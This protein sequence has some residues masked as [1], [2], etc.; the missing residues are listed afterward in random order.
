MSPS[1]TPQSPAT[2]PQSGI[3][4]RWRSSTQRRFTDWTN[5]AID[6]GLTCLISTAIYISTLRDKSSASYMSDEELDVIR[7]YRDTI[8]EFMVDPSKT[9][10]GR[11]WCFRCTYRDD[12]VL[13]DVERG[14]MRL[15]G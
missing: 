10:P 2:E 1:L 5:E 9:G 11:E 13:H 8:H 15:I 14:Q 7:Y 6:L 12:H 3:L 4:S